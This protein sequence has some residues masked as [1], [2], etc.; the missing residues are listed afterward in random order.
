MKMALSIK[1][2]PGRGDTDGRVGNIPK[3]IAWNKY[4]LQGRKDRLKTAY[5]LKAS[6]H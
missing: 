6:N 4:D 2:L 3:S 5:L 1:A